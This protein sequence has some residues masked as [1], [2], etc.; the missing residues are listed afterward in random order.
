MQKKADVCK[1]YWTKLSMNV[2]KNKETC[3][4]RYLKILNEGTWCELRG[5]IGGGRKRLAA[6]SDG[7][8]WKEKAGATSN[9]GPNQNETHTNS[10]I[11]IL[12][13][14]KFNE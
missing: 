4:I 6:S 14:H 8:I 12:Q 7:A 10:H 9:G 1:S 11:Y 13:L 3:W 2:K 5:G